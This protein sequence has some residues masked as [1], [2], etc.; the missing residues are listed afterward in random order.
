M[1]RIVFEKPDCSLIPH[2]IGLIFE[3]LLNPNRQDRLSLVPQNT[4]LENNISIYKVTLANQSTSGLEQY[5]PNPQN[6]NDNYA[7]Y[8]IVKIESSSKPQTPTSEVLPGMTSSFIST[9]THLSTVTLS[10]SSSSSSLN[11]QG[12]QTH[13][14]SSNNN[15]PL[16][17]SQSQ[18]AKQKFSPSSNLAANTTATLK[19]PFSQNQQQQQQQQL[20]TDSVI[21]IVCYFIY[22]NK[23]QSLINT[24]PQTQDPNVNTAQTNTAASVLRR[25]SN[26]TQLEKI[27]LDIKSIQQIIEDAINMYKR[28][29]FWDN[30]KLMLTKG[31]SPTGSQN[32]NTVNM[33]GRAMNLIQAQELEYILLNSH[34][35]NARDLD[36]NYDGLFRQCYTIKEKIFSYFQQNFGNHFVYIPAASCDYCLLLLTNNL[37]R[38]LKS[39][40]KSSQTEQPQNNDS[41]LEKDL[42]SFVLI[43]FDRT[44]KTIDLIHVDGTHEHQDQKELEQIQQQR[45]N[46]RTLTNLSA[47]TENDAS[48]SS[49][50][51]KI[52]LLATCNSIRLN[53]TK[54]T[55]TEH[56]EFIIDSLIYIIWEN[57]FMC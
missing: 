39:K 22:V 42:K 32:S 36:S 31:Q 29:I 5:D 27:K 38:L 24:Q 40:Q 17:I 15:N 7:G 50:N 18:M 53:S 14:N 37:L 55:S 25:I 35:V 49:S 9:N 28:E 34:K 30:L 57:L 20:A 21:R 33:L 4:H 19:L 16:T 1:C 3:F 23:Q 2:K 6:A 12:L 11:T 54:C 41:Q 26:E 10:T 47:L 51:N 43:K 13:P 48:S 8:L 44:N 52:N 45:F 56:I 46:D